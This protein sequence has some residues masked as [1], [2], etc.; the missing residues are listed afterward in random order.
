MSDEPGLDRQSSSSDGLKA[1][2]AWVTIQQKTFTKWMNSH[3]VKKGFPP[4]Q[5]SFM[6]YLPFEHPLLQ[7]CISAMSLLYLT[8]FLVP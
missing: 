1:N 7:S 4:I 8:S 3:L 2:E 5:V 6:N